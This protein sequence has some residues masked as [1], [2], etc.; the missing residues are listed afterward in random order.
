[1]TMT[2]KD[3]I[4]GLLI[5]KSRTGY[6]INEVFETIFKHFYKT[7]YGMIY[8]TLKRLSESGLVEKEIVIQNG[9][10]NKNVYHI[11]DEG[12]QAFKNYLDTEISPEKRESEFLVR[13]YFGQ[14]EGKQTLITWVKD[15]LNLLTKNITQ[16]EEKHHEW[17]E[18]MSYS[19]I[20]AYEIGIA[21]FTAEKKVLEK[22]LAQLEE[23]H[24]NLI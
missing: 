3:I 10:P 13:L 23:K 15:E 9:K 5:E 8:P 11:T 14:S 20:I 1:M 4:L 7:S 19:Q 17:Q 6:E 24:D 2:G 21:Q 16:L 22:Y 12:K 18:K